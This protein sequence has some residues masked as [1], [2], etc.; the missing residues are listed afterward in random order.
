VDDEVDLTTIEDLRELEAEGDDGFVR[1]MVAIYA[2]DSA[3]KLRLLRTAVAHG[4]LERV[5]DLAHNLKGSSR[6]IGAARAGDAAQ[7]LEHHACQPVED[8]DPEQLLQ[9]LEQAVERV[10]PRLEELA[11]S[12]VSARATCR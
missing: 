4:D 11:T 3:T 5:G 1:E 7:A 9:V 2:S 6:S 12:P 8:Q 10:L